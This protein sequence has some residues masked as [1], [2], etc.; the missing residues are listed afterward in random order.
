MFFG[1]PP[2]ASPTGGDELTDRVADTLRRWADHARAAGS[3]P[4][5]RPP[6]R[7]DGR[8]GCCLARRRAHAD[9]PRPRRAGAAR[10]PTASGSACPR[11][12]T[13]CAT[14][15]TERRGA[16]ERNRRLD[17]DA[18]AVQIMTVWVSKGLQ[19][20]LVYLPFAFNR[21]RPRPATSALPRR[22]QRCLDIG[23]AGQP[24][25]QAG[26]GHGPRGVAGDDIRLAYVAL[27][28]AQSQVVAWWAPSG[29]SPTAALSRLLRRPRPRRRRGAGPLPAKVD[30]ARSWPSCALGGRRAGRASS[31]RAGRDAPSPPRAAPTELGVA[32]LRPRRSTRLAPHVVLRADPLRRGGRR[33]RDRARGRRARRRARDELAD[34]PACR[35]APAA[36]AAG[37]CPRR[38]PTCPPGATF[39][40]LVHG[41]AGARRPARARPRAPSCAATSR[42]QLRVVAGRRRR[43]TELADALVPLHH[44]PLGP[45]AAEL[46]LGEIGA[47]RP[48]PRA[49]LR[50]PARR[51]RPARRAPTSPARATSAPLLRPHLAADDP[52][53]RRTPTGS[54]RRARR[55]SRCAATSPARST[56]CSGCRART[57]RATW[58]S[59]T[60][61]T[62][63]ATG[64]PAADRRRLR[65]ADRLA[66]AMLHSDYPLQALL[67]VVVVHRY[68]RW[69]QPG[70]DPA[71]T[72]AA[73]STSTSAACAAPRRRWS[74]GTR[75]GSSAGRRRRRWSTRCPTCSTG[76][77]D[78]D[79]MTP[80]EIEDPHDHR[81]ALGAD[82]LLRDF[83]EAG[84]LDAADVHV[85]R[86]AHRAR[87]RAD[88]RGRARGRARRP[89]RPRRLGLRR[90]GRRRRPELDAD[91][92]WPEPAAWLR[93]ARRQ[94]ADRQPA[95]LR[96]LD[97][98]R[99][100][101]LDR[102]WREEEQVC[103]DLLARPAAACRAADEAAAGGGAR[104]G[105]PGRGLRRAAR[106]G[107]GRARR[108]ATTVL[109]GGPGTGKTTTVA[110]LLALLRRAGRAPR[111]PP[112]L[113][114][115]L[116][117]PTGKAAA[118]LQQAV[119]EEVGRLPDADQ[120]RL[121]RRCGR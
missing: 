52:L 85:A 17:S 94:P 89:R 20:P 96:L 54:R 56:S 41:G 8:R 10:A 107:P 53:R 16:A 114:I 58:S 87:P 12:S 110:A 34:E 103:A 108:S 32:P 42:E 104:P 5:S 19:Y 38:W 83:N 23:G 46:T 67:Y 9:R 37:R 113:R 90:P 97:D 51:R 31:G 86:P 91:L 14:S 116:A 99:L 62:G 27:T 112:A 76:A 68:L 80:L 13:G 100:L 47:A 26:R 93:R 120:A 119:E 121:G 106:R 118:R 29:T 25:L 92:P 40:S 28:R 88:D 64:R 66:E 49:R 55:A 30:D 63:S 39:G 81:L 44:T 15:P 60:R 4:C 48:A 57:V 109:T 82:G 50:D 75:P 7:R 102:Y 105:L 72:S 101:Y 21:L 3:P 43:S 79:R 77:D 2:P 73:C 70:Y 71:P 117:A 35:A 1:E 95:V 69:R 6:S 18:A 98:D 65:P 22:R 78:G 36:A 74:T 111:R 61:P 45:L 11:C 24:G 59:T 33:R 115:A 84:V